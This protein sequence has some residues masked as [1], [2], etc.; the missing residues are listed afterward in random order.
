MFLDSGEPPTPA[1]PPW[2]MPVG[3]KGSQFR[4]LGDAI[5]LDGPGA[6]LGWIPS[7]NRAGCRKCR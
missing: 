5:S 2:G 7:R 4:T 3:R 1:G 6:A